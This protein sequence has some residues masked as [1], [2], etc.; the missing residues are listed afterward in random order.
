MSAPT[1]L[2][3]V[4]SIAGA[5]LPVI[6]FLARLPAALCPIGTLL[7]LT[8]LNGIGQAGLVA[9]M[10]WTGQAVGGPPIGRLA[11]RLGH[12]PVIL[13]ASLANAAAIAA[14][15][16]SV[17]AEAAVVVQAVLAAL[18]GLTIPQV[19][20]LSRTRWIVLTRERPAELTGRA[21]SFDTMVD[22]VGFMV[23]PALAG[24][25]VVL[26]HPVAG[27]VLAGVLIAVFGVLFAVHPTAPRGTPQARV[28]AVRLLSPGLLVLF[29][30]A[31]LQGLVLG[32]ANAGVSALAKHLGDS[33]MAGFVWGAMAVTSVLAGLATTAMPGPWDLTVR[34]R[35]AMVAQAALL[36]PLLVADGYVGAAVVL[37]GVGIAVAPHLIAVFAL[38]ERVA[39]I[40]RM[41]EA[42]ALLGSGLIIGQ[43][44]AALASGQLA[45]RWG[46][47]AAFA[48]SCAAGVVAVAV[49]LAF[50]RR[51][52]F[53]VPDA[54]PRPVPAP[55]QA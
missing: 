7:M 53:A 47:G 3:A 52:P 32:G 40:E 26:V 2:P 15:V 43:G 23:G 50:V 33:G 46:H 6:S 27:M 21:L 42:M 41:G 5:G 9:G 29:A 28:A 4:F 45:Q 37:A 20:P 11:D 44:V 12:R 14:L 55:Q 18:V 13:V 24:T 48:F 17:L 19:G 16:A 38:A 35:L 8:E 49:A 25:V 1:G 31:L 54:A 30:M 10:L 36:F 39:P 51:A 34:L 22:E